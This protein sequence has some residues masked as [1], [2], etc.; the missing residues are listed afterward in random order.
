MSNNRHPGDVNRRTMSACSTASNPRQPNT[1]RNDRLRKAVAPTVIRSASTPTRPKKPHSSST[2]LSFEG[3]SSLIVVKPN[4]VLAVGMLVTIV[5]MV[6]DV[7]FTV[8][9]RLSTTASR[10]RP[11][12]PGKDA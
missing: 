1:K 7:P 3:S 6:V 11:D 4:N 5:I 8:M 10:L 9:P 12:P 2:Y